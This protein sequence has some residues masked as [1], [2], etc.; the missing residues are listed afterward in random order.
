MADFGHDRI[1]TVGLALSEITRMNVDIGDNGPTSS[2]T[3]Q[4]E[5][6]KPT[7]IDFDNAAPQGTRIDV[8][9]KDEL[10]DSTCLAPGAQKKSAALDPP[11]STSPKFCDASA[12]NLCVTKNFRRRPED[13]ARERCY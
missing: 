6:A 2:P 3:M 10:L 5:I 11:A 9:V 1:R 12:P 4:P 13:A 8:V 7:A